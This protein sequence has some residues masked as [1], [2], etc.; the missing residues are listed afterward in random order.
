MMS[1]DIFWKSTSI[2]VSVRMSRMT[3]LSVKIMIIFFQND[4]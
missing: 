2:M 3:V 1:L 4:S